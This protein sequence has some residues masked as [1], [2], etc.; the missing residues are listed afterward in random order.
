MALRSAAARR[1]A[2]ALLAIARPRGDA[3]LAAGQTR[4]RLMADV[5]ESPPLAQ[6]LHNP[7]IAD[8]RKRTLV[9]AALAETVPGLDPEL[10]NLADLLV[11]RQ[12]APLMPAIAEQFAAMV[13]ELRGIEDAEVTT[14]VP[15]SE[16]QQRRL[17]AEL[18]RVTR[19]RIM[20]K[21]RVDP[22]ILGG[23]VLRVG[24]KL[25][26]ASVAGRLAALRRQLV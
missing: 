23:M 12:R 5:I 2:Q 16:D 14:A 21:T 8:E 20:L 1:Y 10:L 3:T 7:A 26:D 15:L 25:V 22:E 4:L 9:R 11:T 24:D 17:E 13:N 19:R 6:L 18:S